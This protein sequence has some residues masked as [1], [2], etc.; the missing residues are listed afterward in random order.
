[1]VFA[2]A[3]LS[4]KPDPGAPE[5]VVWGTGKPRREFLHVDD[6]CVF[7]MEQDSPPEHANIGAGRDITVADLA[8]LIA[9]VVGY[10]GRITFDPSRPDGAPRKLLDVS[11]MKKLGWRPQIVFREGVGATYRWFVEEEAGAGPWC[12]CTCG[13]RWRGA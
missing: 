9:D 7:L 3:L 13:G 1:M 11:R 6:A 4:L 8:S 10:D 12:R 5:V 2:H